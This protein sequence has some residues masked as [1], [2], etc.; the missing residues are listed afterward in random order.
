MEKYEGK[1]LLA[2][3]GWV[4]VVVGSL[5]L[6]LQITGKN[7]LERQRKMWYSMVEEGMDF[8]LLLE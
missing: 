1:A 7:F 8:L 5:S 3:D 2:S 4:V 6:A